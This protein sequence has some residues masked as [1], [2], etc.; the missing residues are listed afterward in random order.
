MGFV[1]RLF[2]K[3]MDKLRG[4]R[5]IQDA[6]PR[7]ILTKIVDYVSKPK[8]RG[9]PRYDAWGYRMGEVHCMGCGHAGSDGAGMARCPRCQGFRFSPAKRLL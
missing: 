5:E 2:G 7:N 8:Q 3:A 4:K 9:K 1:R 6:K